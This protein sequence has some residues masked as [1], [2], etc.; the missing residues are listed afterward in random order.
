MK[1]PYCGNDAELKT[2]RHVYPHRPDL[3]SLKIWACDPCDAWV[4][5]HKNSP[6]HAPLGRLAN[7]ELRKAKMAA[8]AAFDPLWKSGS[9]SRKKAYALL[10]DKM[11]LKPQDT[12]IGMFDVDQCKQVVAVC[13]DIAMPHQPGTF[14]V[15]S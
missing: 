5:T 8:H 9:M 7:A 10:S 1:C 13:H 11:G 2:G 3:A 6:T 14:M 4:G 12:H 15:Y